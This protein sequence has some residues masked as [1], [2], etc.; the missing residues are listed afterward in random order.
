MMVTSKLRHQISLP[1]VTVAEF[2]LLETV[3]ALMF[4]WILSGGLKNE[5]SPALKKNSAAF[6]L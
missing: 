4:P 1:T 5:Q 2:L 6:T 3:Q